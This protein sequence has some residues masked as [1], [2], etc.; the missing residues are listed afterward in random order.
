MVFQ[1]GFQTRPRGSN[2]EFSVIRR[3]L[4][5]APGDGLAYGRFLRAE[6]VRTFLDSKLPCSNAD[7]NTHSDHDV[8]DIM[9]GF[10]LDITVE[11]FIGNVKAILRHFGSPISVVSIPGLEEDTSI[12]FRTCARVSLQHSTFYDFK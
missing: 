1:K 7:K 11:A 5:I 9:S 12:P 10:S 6:R 2:F 3:S 4:A 8:V